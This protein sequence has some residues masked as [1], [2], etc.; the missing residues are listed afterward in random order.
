[1]GIRSSAADRL[2]FMLRAV[3]RSPVLWI[4]IVRRKTGKNGFVMS[5]LFVHVS[6]DGIG[7]LYPFIGLFALLE[8]NLIPRT[9]IFSGFL[10]QSIP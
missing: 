1:M 4:G 2:L 9:Q 7:F 3:F 8:N 10:R 6:C 5:Y